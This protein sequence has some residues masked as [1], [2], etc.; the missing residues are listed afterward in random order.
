VLLNLLQYQAELL[1]HVHTACLSW[2]GQASDTRDGGALSWEE[3]G[4]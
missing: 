2:L 1:P 3:E 4:M